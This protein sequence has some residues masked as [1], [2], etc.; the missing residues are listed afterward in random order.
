[1]THSRIRL[2]MLGN[3]K[4]LC[5]Q[6]NCIKFCVYVN[7]QVTVFTNIFMIY[8]VLS[9]NEYTPFEK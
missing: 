5:S 1:M 3:V 4:D 9:V 8:T 7:V 6:L 2:E